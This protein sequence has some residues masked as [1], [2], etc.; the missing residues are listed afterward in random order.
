M[1]HATSGR[2]STGQGQRQSPPPPTNLKELKEREHQVT[3]Q[4]LAE[5]WAQLKFLCHF[6][7]RIAIRRTSD[8]IGLG[9][10]VSTALSVYFSTSNGFMWIMITL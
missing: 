6:I 5:H 7:Y 9:F 1:L 10:F 3:V 2:S 4:I 8:K